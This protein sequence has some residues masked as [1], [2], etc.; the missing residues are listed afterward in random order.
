M[1]PFRTR[2]DVAAAV[3]GLLGLGISAYGLVDKA[4]CAILL[5]YEPQPQGQP[6]CSAGCASVGESAKEP[7]NQ[8]TFNYRAA[9][10]R[11]YCSNTISDWRRQ[12]CT[13]PV[14]PGCTRI[15]PTIPPVSEG[16]CCIF[17][18]PAPN[19]FPNPEGFWIPACDGDP[20]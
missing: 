5:K 4:C 15:G 13:T 10:C 17:C 11:T 14:P 6:L 18:G 7:L 1:R 16:N 8:W 19:E 20:C 12:L 3:I 2:F 9:L